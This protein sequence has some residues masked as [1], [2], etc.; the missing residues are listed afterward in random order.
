MINGAHTI[1][2]AEDADAARAFFRDVLN[3]PNV[4]ANDG[5]LIFKSPPAELAVHPA[6]GPDSARAELFLMCDD[7]DA[8]MAELGA[9][10]VEFTTGVTNAGWG[11]LTHFQ[12]PGAGEIGLYQPR[13]ATAYDLP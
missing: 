6:E 1:L 11:L 10:G 7:L 4:D 3:L 2:Y 8:T 13:H 12:I 5:W 9:K